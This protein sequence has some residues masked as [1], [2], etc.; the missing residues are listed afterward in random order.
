LG[1][2]SKKA[3]RPKTLLNA[4]ADQLY[5]PV[6]DLEKNITQ[7]QQSVLAL[8]NEIIEIPSQNLKPHEPIAPLNQE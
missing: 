4:L 7:K 2:T 1:S 6:D 3:E 8:Y 5:C